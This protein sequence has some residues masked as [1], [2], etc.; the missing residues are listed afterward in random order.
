MEDFLIFEGM[1][2]INKYYKK[3]IDELFW[4][5]EELQKLIFESIVDSNFI[6]SAYMSEA[7]AVSISIKGQPWYQ[8]ERFFNF[9]K[10][11]EKFYLKNKNPELAESYSSQADFFRH[12]F[13]HINY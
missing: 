13:F 8:K 11:Q 4:T 5:L 7:N 12:E 10:E 2:N 6:P 9:L 1:V 3:S